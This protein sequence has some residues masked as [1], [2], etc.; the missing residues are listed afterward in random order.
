MP[1]LDLAGVP[2]GE[3]EGGGRGPLDLGVAG[4][5]DRF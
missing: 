5:G 4:S 2:R 1:E 3:G